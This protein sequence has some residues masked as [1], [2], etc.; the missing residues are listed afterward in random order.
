M[1]PIE[2]ATY[3]ELNGMTNTKM[4]GARVD[5]QGQALGNVKGPVQNLLYNG[6]TH[7]LGGEDHLGR[8]VALS[9]ESSVLHLCMR[10]AWKCLQ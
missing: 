6:L 4:K 7:D 10:A 2:L 9:M 3:C 8:S 1:L 5:G